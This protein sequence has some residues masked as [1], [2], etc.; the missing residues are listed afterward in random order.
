M[1]IAKDGSI[2]VA[3]HGGGVGHYQ[4]NEWQNYSTQEDLVSDSF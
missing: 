3:P 4:E 2:W 1:A